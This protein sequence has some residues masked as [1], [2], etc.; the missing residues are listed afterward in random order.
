[1]EN[2]EKN[3]IRREWKTLWI[4][5]LKNG[6]VFSSSFA[7]VDTPVSDSSEIETVRLGS[8]NVILSLLSQMMYKYVV[9]CCRRESELWFW[10]IL[11]TNES[12]AFFPKAF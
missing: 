9:C 1:M 8:L 6:I 2:S 12:N 7:V 3:A 5:Y 10:Q 4:A 11:T